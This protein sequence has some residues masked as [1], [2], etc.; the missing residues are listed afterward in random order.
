MQKIVKFI[1]KFNHN[2]KKKNTKLKIL[3]KKS[4]KKKNVKYFIR[5]INFNIVYFL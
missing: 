2:I 5:K 3:L 1:V 4:K